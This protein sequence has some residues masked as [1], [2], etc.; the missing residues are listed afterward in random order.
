[1][2]PRRVRAKK[3]RRENFARNETKRMVFAF[4][5]FPQLWTPGQV[6]KLTKIDENRDFLA[7][8]S[9]IKPLKLCTIRFLYQE[10]YARF[11]CFASHFI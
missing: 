1:M 11:L 2:A 7:G 10:Q 4:K 3:Q 5:G 6:D 8:S 9:S